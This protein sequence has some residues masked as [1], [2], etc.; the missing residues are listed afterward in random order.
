VQRVL[1]ELSIAPLP[2]WLA[3][4][5]EIRGSAR[6]RRVYDFLAASLPLQV[7]APRAAPPPVT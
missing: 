2:M 4:H 7:A 3:V 6:I 5:R 1:P